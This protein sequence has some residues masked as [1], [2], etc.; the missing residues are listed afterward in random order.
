MELLVAASLAWTIIGY[1]I[2]RWVPQW[3]GE[4][5]TSGKKRA[6]HQF[7]G[8]LQAD[9][10][11]VIMMLS[12][13]SIMRDLD[14]F[15]YSEDGFNKFLFNMSFIQNMALIINLLIN[16]IDW[17]FYLNGC[18]YHDFET[19]FIHHPLSIIGI[20]YQIHYQIGGGIMSIM[21]LD[22]LTALIA[23]IWDLCRPSNLNSKS[24]RYNLAIFLK[25]YRIAYVL[26][27]LIIYSALSLYI[28]FLSLDVL[29]LNPQKYIHL[30]LE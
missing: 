13:S 29:L 22:T 16:S 30:R 20:I 19:L 12:V 3:F 5:K 21:L 4:K 23:A 18:D 26:T 7:N 6:L 25:L 10:S 8:V 15:Y 2:G 9:A 11:I 17:G 28:L 1:G 24:T 27:R 14:S